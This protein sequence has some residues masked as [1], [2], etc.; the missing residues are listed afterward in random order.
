MSV[1]AITG[2]ASTY[3]LLLIEQFLGSQKKDTCKY[4][5]LNH[6]GNTCA[7]HPPKGLV[8]FLLS[9]RGQRPY[10]I[11]DWAGLLIQLQ[12]QNHFWWVQVAR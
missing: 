12:K 2:I 11:C 8:M 5:C 10:R 3:D 6:H 1:R 7:T 4:T 9:Q